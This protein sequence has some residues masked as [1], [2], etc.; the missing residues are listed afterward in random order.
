[1][2]NVSNRALFEAI[3]NAVVRAMD[4]GNAPT[5]WIPNGRRVVRASDKKYALVNNQLTYSALEDCL[6]VRDG[7]SD[8]RN[9]NRFSGRAPDGSVN[10][11]AVYFSTHN[12][13]MFMEIRHYHPQRSIIKAL[14]G[15][16]VLNVEI[17]QPM[18]VMDLS[19]HSASTTKFLKSLEQDPAIKRAAG[20]RPL[21]MY[22]KMLAP[23]DYTV[24]R[25]IGLAAGRFSEIDGLIAPTA[26]TDLDNRSGDNLILFGQKGSRVSRK[27]KILTAILFKLKRGP[28]ELDFQYFR[29]ERNQVI[30]I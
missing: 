15:K 7:S 18:L 24:S 22:N 11:G 10:V 17:T 26:R 2:A 12:V 20:N 19:K 4:E 8:D 9:A 6:E 25:A 30:P 3:Y 16:L 5:L 13:P 27:L 1:M 14:K 28:G 21:S 23:N 29:V